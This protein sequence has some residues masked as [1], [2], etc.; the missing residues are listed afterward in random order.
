V[1]EPTRPPNQL[2]IYLRVS[3]EE[4]RERESI[5]TQCNF[6]EKYCAL[7]DQVPYDWYA[8]DGVSGTIAMEMR[9]EGARLLQDARAG[10]I[11]M[12]LV[13]RVDRIGRKAKHVLNAV[14]AL[15]ECGVRV[16]SMTEPFD[17]STPAGRL[18]LTML[19]GFADFER[20]SI[21]ERSAEGTN[22]RA[23]AGAWLGG[24]APYGYFLQG[25]KNDARLVVS[26]QRMPGCGL[27]EADVIRLLYRRT[28]EDNWPCQ[29]IADELNAL[30]VPPAYVRDG[31]EVRAKR[32][33]T[34]QSLWSAGRIR[35]ML[36]NATYKGVH[37]Y[38]RRSAKSGREIIEREVPAIVGVETWDRAQEHLHSHMLMSMRN[39]KHEYL[40]RG[41][42]RCGV[43][44]LT[45]NGRFDEKRQ[46][47]FYTCNGKTQARG[48][49]G[50]QGL[51]CPSKAIKGTPLE[52]AIWDDIEDFIRNPGDVL[53]QL[54]VR[55]GEQSGQAEQLRDRLADLQQQLHAKQGEKDMVI[56]LYRRGRIDA[57]ELDRQ[58]DQV[59]EE[60][61]TLANQA[62]Y[63]QEQLQNGRAVEESLHSAEALLRQLNER[64]DEPLTFERKR[65][66]V[67]VL[68]ESIRLDVFEDES[69]K[70]R[71][72]AV[73]TYR[74][75]E[76]PVVIAAR[77]GS[78]SSS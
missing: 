57:G 73:V 12:L 21:L 74:F 48:L 14:G 62:E 11:T 42:I 78:R 22:R 56:A 50:S 35:N 46:M 38:G 58:L 67:E 3:T 15:E 27:S 36:A 9:P 64:M 30:G 7:H 25:E 18:M 23:R 31:R 34:V 68:V 2:G 44:G 28:V 55:L 39:A 49:Y 1:T 61:T 8:D 51:R 72:K 76:T 16:V 6:A 29:R 63:V 20:D 19:S 26:E 5:L 43:C 45:C 10:K 40:L 59:Q 4:Q 52:N 33:A 60:A 70:Q 41:L 71:T 37:R 65:H 47:A 53:D 66:Y 32:T 77:R 69:G 17:T 54:A 13:Y 24:V 75:S